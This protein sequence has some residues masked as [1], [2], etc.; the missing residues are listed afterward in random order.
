VPKEE[1]A[2]VGRYNNQF[3]DYMEK[4]RHRLIPWVY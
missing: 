3:L 1:E 2:L 4:V